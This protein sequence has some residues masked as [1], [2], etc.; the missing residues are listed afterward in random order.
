MNR[1][2]RSDGIALVA[3]YGRRSGF[4]LDPILFWV[5]SMRIPVPDPNWEATG[6]AIDE[7]HHSSQ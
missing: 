1:S 2:R 6:T 3:L 7:R 5:I 4:E